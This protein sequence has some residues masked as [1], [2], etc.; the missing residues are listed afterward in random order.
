MYSL[1]C[2]IFPT[3][4]VLII[5]KLKKK[6]LGIHVVILELELSYHLSVEEERRLRKYDFPKLHSKLVLELGL[7]PRFLSFQHC[8]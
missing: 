5:T 2:D 7:D 1:L 6:F 3:V 8:P 4:Y